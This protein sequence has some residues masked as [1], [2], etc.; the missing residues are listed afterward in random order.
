MYNDSFIKKGRLNVI[1]ELQE[2]IKHYNN[3]V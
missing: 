2:N 1:L 3:F